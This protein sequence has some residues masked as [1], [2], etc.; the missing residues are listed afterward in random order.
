[1]EVLAWKA[2]GQWCCSQRE[3]SCEGT[4]H[5]YSHRGVSGW[6][7]LQILPAMWDSGNC[8]LGCTFLT[9][10][11]VP[12]SKPHR[13]CPES[14][15]FTRTRVHSLSLFCW[16][17]GLWNIFPCLLW[18]FARTFVNPTALGDRWCY[19][20]SIACCPYSVVNKL[21]LKRGGALEK[22][23]GGV[24]P[25]VRKHIHFLTRTLALEDATSLQG[26]GPA[27]W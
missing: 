12:R 21:V 10:E 2:K 9:G 15:V 4:P 18:T 13:L 14:H 11:P 22:S 23:N 16:L 27:G 20:Y 24:S 5:F 25:Q 17:T 3:L 1:M 7:F 19:S 26:R 6:M 8:L